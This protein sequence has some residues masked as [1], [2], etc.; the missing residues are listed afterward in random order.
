MKIL[1]LHPHL[2]PISLTLPWDENITQ[3]NEK[4]F[5]NPVRGISRNPVRFIV[6]GKNIYAIKQLKNDVALHEFNSLRTLTQKE[7]PAVEPIALVTER[8]FEKDTS[9]V[10]TLFLPYSIPYRSIMATQNWLYKEDILI[11]AMAE[12]LVWMHL[13][14]VYWG[15]CSLSNTLF[16]EDAGRLCA[17]LVDAETSETYDNISDG[18]RA[19]DLQIAKSNLGGELSDLDKGFGLPKSVDINKLTANLEEKYSALWNELNATKLIKKEESY[20][21]NKHLSRLEELGYDV[22]S[23]ELKTTKN[24]QKI[25]VT[26]SIIEPGFFIKKLFD[27]TGL[28][29]QSKQAKSLLNDINSYAMQ[30]GNII[31]NNFERQMQNAKDWY[32]TVYLKTITQIPQENRQNQDEVELYCQILEHKWYKSEQAQKDIG[33][34]E[35]IKSFL[36][37]QNQKQT[38]VNLK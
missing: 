11:D 3:W 36:Q 34:D 19:L 32:H 30:C 31:K 29:V 17:Y 14:G 33:L 5:I 26:T 35:S 22:Q 27:L 38:L 16:K 4:S 13:R 12:L 37:E 21:I 24:G 1:Q 9:L 25:Q 23:L 20:K 18:Q 2:Y 7:A 10:V 28:K 15:D 6:H 8:E